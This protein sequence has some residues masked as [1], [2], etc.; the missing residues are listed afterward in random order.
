LHT[1]PRNSHRI[2]QAS[3]AVSTAVAGPV[4]A[5]L[6]GLAVLAYSLG[7]ALFGWVFLTNWQALAA[8]HNDY[9]APQV[10]DDPSPLPTASPALGPAAL[11]VPAIADLPII[12]EIRPAT[13]L[14]DWRGTERVNILLLGIDQRPDEKPDFA[15]TDTMLLVSVDPVEKS[16]ALLSFPRD[17]WLTIPGRGQQ[18]INVAHALGGPELSKKTIEANFG[19]R[20]QYFARINF[21]GFEEMVDTL[22]GVMV[23]V[24]RPIKD[25]E[26][27]TE[28]YGYM[29]VYIPAGPQMMDGR[30]ALQY[31]RSRHSENDFGRMRRQQ[32]VLLAMRNR[33]MQLDMLP[34]LPSLLGALQRAAATDLSPTEILALAKL[35]SQIEPERVETL[36]ID[37]RYVYSCPGE[38]GAAL[39]CPHMAQIRQAIS[40]LMPSGSQS[41]ASR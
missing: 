33:A 19:I 23:D 8:L 15:R 5:A 16:A 12:R 13:I 2:G 10:A 40:R 20:V 3:R 27:P 31:A 24:E 6:C 25:D 18:R 37:G 7:G 38:D 39:L 26:Y 34:R 32:K 17:L 4:L 29:R 11:T 14:P 41:A 21:K 22:G 1:H 9:V 36:V 28:D 35:G 30:T